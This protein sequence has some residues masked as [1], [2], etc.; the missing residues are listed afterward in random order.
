MD[1]GLSRVSPL[2]WLWLRPSRRSSL[3][4][5]F[6]EIEVA[7][8]ESVVT[9]SVAQGPRLLSF[10]PLRDPV[11]EL[12]KPFTP[13]L[14]LSI[15]PLRTSY[16]EGTGALYSTSSSPAHV[17]RPPPTFANTGMSRRR[18]SRAAEDIVALG[19]K[20][21]SNAVTNTLSAIGDLAKLD[22]HLERQYCPVV[23]ARRS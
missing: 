23:Q 7:F 15:A 12:L 6:P 11:P 16:Y 9:R 14:R 10:N 8:C 22:R 1:R 20:D 17:A 2:P 13:T 5:G 19:D 4:P 18:N 3:R 21:Y